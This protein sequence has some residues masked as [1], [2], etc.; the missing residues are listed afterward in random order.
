[1]IS[2]VRTFLQNNRFF[3][4]SLGVHTLIF[5]ILLTSNADKKTFDTSL[6][7][8]VVE[9]VRSESRQNSSDSESKK[10]LRAESMIEPLKV[11]NL[12]DQDLVNQSPSD[13][14]IQQLSD[15]NQ[16]SEGFSDV[17]KE[18][19]SHQSYLDRIRSK[20]EFHKTYPKAS[21]VLKE[22]GLVKVKL[23]IAKS[24][25][26]QK[27]EISESSQFKRLDEAAIKA[28]A[29]ASPFDEFPSDVTFAVWSILVPMRFEL[30]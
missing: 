8:E 26:I 22:T 10:R 1:L 12:L 4:C 14:G 20:I 6:D 7:I 27:I 23:K 17:S 24:G 9:S 15:Q 5:S 2:S 25:H 30:N 16:I 13:P 11:R 28:A 19:N 29:D 3:L 21:R 18:A